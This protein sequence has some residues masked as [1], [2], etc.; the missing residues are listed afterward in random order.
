M[1]KLILVI[2]GLGLAMIL[3]NCKVKE[4]TAGIPV[5]YPQDCSYF[6]V[7]YEKGTMNGL[8]PKAS[9]ETIKK[10]FPC[11]TGETE[12]GSDFNCGGGLFYLD[13]DFYFYTHRDYLELREGFIPDSTSMKL[14]GRSR[15]KLAEKLGTPDM[16]PEEDVYLYKKPYGTLRIEFFDGVVTETG[17]HHVDIE[18]IELCM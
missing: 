9:M 11:F 15:I 10:A 3:T 6:Y 18:D 13:H 14:L 12:E 16:Q 2:A 8:S 17:I 1:K 5:T 7:D 4:K